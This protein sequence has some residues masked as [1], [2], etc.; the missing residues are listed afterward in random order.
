MADLKT[1][2]N[3]LL[4]AFLWFQLIEIAIIFFFLFYLFISYY[5]TNWRRFFHDV[6][7]SNHRYCN[8]NYYIHSMLANMQSD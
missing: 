4:R 6:M 2:N 8:S 5:R 3:K 7:C 1:D